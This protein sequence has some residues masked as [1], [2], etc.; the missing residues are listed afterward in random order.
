MQKK[1]VYV[2][3]L[4]SFCVL[5]ITGLQMYWNYQNYNAVVSNFKKDVNN[6]LDVAVNREIMDRHAELIKQAK[7][8][9]ADT[10]LITITCDINNRDSATVFTVSDTHPRFAEDKGR[11]KKIS[12]G[13]SKITQKLRKITP[14]AKKMFIQHF[15]DNIIKTDL[16]SG[17]VYYYTQGLG[18]SLVKAKEESRV[19]FVNLNKW[20][21]AELSRNKIYSKF[22][23]N[24][25]SS[26]VANLFIT[27]KV[28]AAIRR[29]YIKEM[30]WASLENPNKYYIREMKWLIISSALLIGITLFCFY[31]TL[32][33]LL[34][35][36]KLVAIKNQF[37]NSMTHEINTPLA[38][39]QVTTEALQQ[40]NHTKETQDKYLDIIL[41]QTKKLTELSH[42]ILE[43]AKLETLAISRDESIDLD[44]LILS[45]IEDVN[46]I[47]HAKIA[48]QSPNETIIVKGNRG[49][50]T[51]SISNVLENAFKYNIS[52]QPTIEINLSRSSQGVNLSIKDNGLGIA[53]EYKERIFDQFFR[54]PTGDIHDIKGYGLGLNYVKKVI[55]Q[56]HGR[57]S[58]LDNFPAGTEFS[59]IL[60][61]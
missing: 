60:P 3:V 11:G 6:A 5:G 54:V 46:I 57:I 52:P 36:Y 53:D 25:K 9:M 23:I 7:V 48:Y 61:N 51:R 26:N 13:I 19:N 14:E 45:I 24:P 1:I 43:N 47:R 49:H 42:E 8:W 33:T 28:N 34:S 31:Y 21:K 15:A 41:Y 20:F 50:L 35:Q 44:Q 56:H 59:I 27:N 32:K 12:L 18:D 40:F 37:I 29:P 2:L 30:I 22:K 16:E 55:T 4:M 39:I 17:T 10:S 58:V 38:S